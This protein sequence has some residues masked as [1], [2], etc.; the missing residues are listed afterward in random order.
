MSRIFHDIILS[1]EFIEEARKTLPGQEAAELRRAMIDLLNA[2]IAA[3]GAAPDA[4]DLGLQ[5]RF[6]AGH[7]D[8]EE[9]AAR[10]K[11]QLTG[12]LGRPR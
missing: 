9:I 4:D 5:A 8:P 7:L 11:S 2:Q 3:M 12:R 6:I 1:R 10:I